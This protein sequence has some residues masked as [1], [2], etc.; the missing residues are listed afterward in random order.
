MLGGFSAWRRDF[1]AKF[2]GSLFKQL[3]NN[4]RFSSFFH[5]FLLTPLLDDIAFL[6]TQIF[7]QS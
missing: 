7:L 6:P 3:T 1:K 2:A 4:Q 5:R